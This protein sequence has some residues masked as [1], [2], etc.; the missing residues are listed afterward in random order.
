MILLPFTSPPKKIGEILE[1]K[2]RDAMNCPKGGG[3]VSLGVE[4]PRLREDVIEEL[5][6]YAVKSFKVV[7]STEWCIM[8]APSH[9]S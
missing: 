3:E 6:G 2:E 8:V 9:I 1:K 5:R 4:D 7:F